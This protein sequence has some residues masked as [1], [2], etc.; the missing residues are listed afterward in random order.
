[1]VHQGVALAAAIALV[2]ALT[3]AVT[4]TI[5]ALAFW[6]TAAACLGLVYLLK[7]E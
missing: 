4:G 2:V 7:K 5:P 3:L 1:M 6:L